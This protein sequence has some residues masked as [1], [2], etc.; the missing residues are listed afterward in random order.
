MA[1]AGAD[2]DQEASGIELC[3]VH[4]G[5]RVRRQRETGPNEATNLSTR[6]VAAD[7]RSLQR[8][9]ISRQAT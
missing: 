2:P 9:L 6:N 3:A 7:W 1:A 4:T 8:G 5:S